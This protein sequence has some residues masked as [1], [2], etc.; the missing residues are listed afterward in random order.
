MLADHA[1]D[2]SDLRPWLFVN[3]LSRL[4]VDPERFPDDR[5]E[6]EAVGMGAV[7]TR[8][9]D[10]ETLRYET[11][12]LLETY[13]DPYAHAFARLVDDR[14]HTVGSVT[15][16]DLHSFPAEALP[17]ELH[18]D[19][20]R[21]E[22]CLGTDP[23]H[24][25]R[26]LVDEARRALWAVGVDGDVAVDTPFAGCYVPLHLYGRNSMV[27]AVMV[28]VRRDLITSPPRER[29]DDGIRRVA[30]GLAS[31]MDQAAALAPTH[32]HAHGD[33]LARAVGVSDPAL[34]SDAFRIRFGGR[35]A[36]PLQVADRGDHVVL[37]YAGKTSRHVVER[38]TRVV[39]NVSR[40]RADV[41]AREILGLLSVSP[42]KPLGVVCCRPPEIA[43]PPTVHEG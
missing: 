6:M 41:M 17:Y 16:I 11:R 26:A 9:S 25:P 34:L 22:I 3:R 32:E 7:Y 10:G 29:Y 13:F 20:H 43:P 31:L 40:S 28:E 1:A 38:G 2:A 36:A 18:G 37:R 15:I 14:L 19:G 5:E 24:T 33:A 42:R 4:V 12:G 23:F 35:L 30:R 21:P 39:S 27:Q 8:T